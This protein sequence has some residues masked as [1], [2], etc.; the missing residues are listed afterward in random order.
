M[1]CLPD[2]PLEI[3]LQIFEFAC[4]DEGVTSRSLSQTSRY[5]REASKSFRYY[6]V[7]I[8]G[9]RQLL[10][11]EEQFTTAPFDSR[12]L[13]HLYVHIPELYTDAYPPESWFEDEESDVDS[14][15]IPSDEEDEEDDEQSKS[16]D[17]PVTETL[18]EQ[19]GGGS[20]GG[21]RPLQQDEAQSDTS[22]EDLDLEE[23]EE[24][25][26]EDPDP[27]PSEIEDFNS[28]GA[29]ICTSQGQNIPPIH[30]Q[31]LY[32]LKDTHLRLARLEY[33]VFSALRRVLEAS[34]H[35]L[36]TFTL[37]WSPSASLYLEAVIPPLPALRYLAILKDTIP[38]EDSAPVRYKYHLKRVSPAPILFPALEELKIS[39]RSTKKHFA[40]DDDAFNG[41][42]SAP[43]KSVS[44]PYRMVK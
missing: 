35:S 28:E 20:T 9:W 12:F 13:V 2:L 31:D 6:S 44:A 18:E 26:L 1:A 19:E 24:L 15:Y 30:G 25:A 39:T 5:L 34:A 41:L 16:E 7:A 42:L 14:T 23:L 43:L 27:S 38:Q 3:W 11:F 29:D 22:D 37:C 36:Q 40:W 21:K 33:Q 10:A 17:V 4:A 32:M 8:K